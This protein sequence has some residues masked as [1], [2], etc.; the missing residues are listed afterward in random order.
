MKKS[1]VYLF[2]IMST[3][4]VLLSSCKKD[5]GDEGNINDWYNVLEDDNPFNSGGVG[6]KPQLEQKDNWGYNCD[7][8]WTKANCFDTTQFVYELC[9]YKDDYRDMHSFGRQTDTVYHFS[10]D[11]NS[12]G[13]FIKGKSYS[14]MLYAYYYFNNHEHRVSAD[15]QLG[16]SLY[17]LDDNAFDGRIYECSKYKD[18]VVF[19][20]IIDYDEILDPVTEFNNIIVELCD[21][22]DSKQIVKKYAEIQ[23]DKTKDDIVGLPFPENWSGNIYVRLY[24][25][26]GLLK[27]YYYDKVVFI[28]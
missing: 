26:E 28:D 13:D 2:T 16:T 12:P 22:D 27:Y 4:A 23:Y 10:F 7:I 21:I 9:W 14:L 8:S 20:F 17:I 25:A 15:H 5:D 11:P 19:H 3:T 1:V 6:V 18:N 24:D